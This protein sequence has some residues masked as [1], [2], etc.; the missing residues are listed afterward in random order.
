[1]RSRSC[2]PGADTHLLLIGLLEEVEYVA[3]FVVLDLLRI[4]GCID[5]A[6]SSENHF[7]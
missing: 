3:W 6:F 5:M 4:P 7:Q 1:M 2:H